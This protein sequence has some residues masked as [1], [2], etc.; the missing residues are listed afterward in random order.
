MAAY[1]S[2]SRSIREIIPLAESRPRLDKIGA[3][4][5]IALAACLASRGRNGESAPAG[6][7]EPKAPAFETGANASL[8]APASYE[9]LRASSSRRGRGRFRPCFD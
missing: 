3:I 5:Y 1:D 7:V 9:A 8:P 4:V 2:A 6:I